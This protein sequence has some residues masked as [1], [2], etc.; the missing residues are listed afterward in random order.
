M[1][2]LNDY[3]YY[4]TLRTFGID[5]EM[6][7]K[8]TSDVIGD[9]IDIGFNENNLVGK[10][11]IGKNSVDDIALE[12]VLNK[13]NT[14]LSDYIYAD[15][16]IELNEALVAELKKKGAKVSV[17]ESITGGLLSSEIC[18]VEGAS[19]VFYEGIITYNSGS[20]VRRLHV[21]ATTIASDSA[22]AE[23][24]TTE[25]LKGILAN[26]EITYG[27]ATT[28]Y[29]SGMGTADGQAY[30]AYGTHNEQNC[31][32]IKYDGE[33]NEIRAKVANRAMFELLKMIKNYNRGY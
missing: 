26:K 28:G 16:D 10:I 21:S 4:C 15:Y 13:L 24:T 27:I 5:R 3:V 7:N 31:I 29:A 25:M 14:I 30:I 6:F 18:G 32:E 11:V 19:D 20:K 12:G 22:V 2:K 33:R 8:F 1:S 17:A 9:S 23:S